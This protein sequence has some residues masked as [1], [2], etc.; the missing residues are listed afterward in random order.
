[1]AKWD[2][3]TWSELGGMDALS[4]NEAIMSICTD[5]A[6]SI[7][8]TGIFTDTSTL[9]VRWATVPMKHPFYVAKYGNTT[10]GVSRLTVA[11]NISVYPNPAGNELYVSGLQH[12]SRYRLLNTVGLVVQEG[13]VDNVRN[14]IDLKNAV[15]G[16]CI[17]EVADLSTGFRTTNKII[18]E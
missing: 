18:K 3:S 9:I 10:T 15:K 2:G 1:M 8:A 5:S 17:L 16:V 11:A 7:Y 14:A 13:I 4:A 12:P 6:G